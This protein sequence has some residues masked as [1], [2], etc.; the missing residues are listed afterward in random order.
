MINISFEISAQPAWDVP[1]MSQSDLQW[2]RHLK[3]LSKTSQKRRL[4]CDVFKMSQ[5]HLKKDVFFDTY[6]RRLKYISEKMFF[7]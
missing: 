5:K 3:D 1:E 2:E 7:M 6:L 4:F